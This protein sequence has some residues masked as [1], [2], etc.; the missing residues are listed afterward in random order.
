MCFRKDTHM[1]Y[2][3]G[4]SGPKYH[5]EYFLDLADDL[6]FPEWFDPKQE[7]INQV[8]GENLPFSFS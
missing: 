8:C 4:W 3:V 7:D 2:V 6:Q 1:D 5:G